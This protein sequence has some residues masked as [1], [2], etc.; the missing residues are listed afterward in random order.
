MRQMTF[1]LN[2]VGLT[3]FG[4]VPNFLLYL[5][6]TNTASLTRFGITAL[7]QPNAALFAWLNMPPVWRRF[8]RME[9][10]F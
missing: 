7:R 6:R 1:S 8:L 5:R 4:K 3:T 2:V 10:R 9:R